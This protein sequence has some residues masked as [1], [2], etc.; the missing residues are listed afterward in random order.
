MT[1]TAFL[2]VFGISTILVVGGFAL[3][4]VFK[5]QLP[6][7]PDIHIDFDERKDQEDRRRH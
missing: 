2:T 4:S 7:R 3:Y 6:S 5:K 1:T